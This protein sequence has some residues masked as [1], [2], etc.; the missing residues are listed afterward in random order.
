MSAVVKGLK[1]VLVCSV[2]FS[3]HMVPGRDNPRAFAQSAAICEIVIASCITYQHSAWA[4]NS[5]PEQS[6]VCRCSRLAPG[7]RWSREPV[8]WYCVCFS[9]D[10][11][12]SID[13]VDA[14]LSSQG[15]LKISGRPAFG[16]WR[17]IETVNFLE[18]KFA[19]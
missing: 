9:S 13:F 10:R 16:S 19:Q 15:L 7:S 17:G 1:S 2:A 5:I 3:N 4:P 14:A 11:L 18:R 12:G 8:H 6:G